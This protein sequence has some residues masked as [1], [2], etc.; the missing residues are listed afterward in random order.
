MDEGLT[1]RARDKEEGPLGF[2]V[3]KI[4]GIQTSRSR[5]SV[6][7]EELGFGFG[8]NLDRSFGF[9]GWRERSASRT[10]ASVCIFGKAERR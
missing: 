9:T 6:V 5:R 4:H 1:A 7:V 3:G 2:W 10:L 8:S